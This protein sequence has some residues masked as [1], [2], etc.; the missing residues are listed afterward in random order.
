MASSTQTVVEEASVEVPLDRPVRMEERADLLE[1]DGQRSSWPDMIS[2][3]TEINLNIGGLQVNLRIGGFILLALVLSIVAIALWPTSSSPTGSQPSD[4]FTLDI[5][6][7]SPVNVSAAEDTKNPHIPV[8]LE[9]KNI[10]EFD[11][12]KTQS[13]QAMSTFSPALAGI[14]DGEV[15][16]AL[17]T[18]QIKTIVMVLMQILMIFMLGYN[19]IAS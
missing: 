4:A 5:S 18:D 11:R 14:S 15:S 12:S 8:S 1:R 19:A 9:K 7:I 3:A 10:A 6:N 17:T 13:V 2:K 16:Q